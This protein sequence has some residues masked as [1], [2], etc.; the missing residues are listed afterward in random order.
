MEI[1]KKICCVT[2]NM[3]IQTPSIK[4]LKDFLENTKKKILH[5]CN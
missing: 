2:W 1:E 3:D 5:I 4:E